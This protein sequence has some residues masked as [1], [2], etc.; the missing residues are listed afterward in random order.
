[1]KDNKIKFKG[2]T[3]SREHFEL[4]YNVS[5][6]DIESNSLTNRVNESW[7]LHVQELRLLAFKHIREKMSDLGYKVELKGTDIQFMKI[8]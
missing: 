8:S 3:I 2:F 1:M 4:K 5:L 7:E 6:S